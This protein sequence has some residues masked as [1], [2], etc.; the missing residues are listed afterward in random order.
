MS[1]TREKV[2][3]T[4]LT[5]PRCTINELAAEVG[6]SP[7]SV[8][9]HINA[10]QA[11]GLVGY[12]E[13]RHGVG[14]P[15]Q[16]YFLTEIGIEQFPTRYVRLTLRLLEQIKETMPASMVGALFT[17]IAQDLVNEMASG[18]EIEKLNM[19][20]RLELATNILRR[21]GFSIEW[22]KLGDAFQ[23]REVSCPYYFIGQDHPEV[24]AMGEALISSVLA[25]PIKKTMCILNGDAYCAYQISNP[26]A[27]EK[28]L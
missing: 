23:I 12:K 6:I 8:R 17:Q 24:C 20:E 3:R 16:I 13:E 26:H 11:E 15:H 5:H 22:E 7:I 19:Q 9:H 10:L 28:N 2:L 14:R 4:L 18:V 25:T 21:E 27:L 1:V